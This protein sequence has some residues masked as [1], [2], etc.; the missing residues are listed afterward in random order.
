MEIKNFFPIRLPTG[1][2]VTLLLGLFF[3]QFLF[4]CA[5]SL[6]VSKRFGNQGFDTAVSSLARHLVEQGGLQGRP[7]LISPH[8]FYDLNS[9][10]SLPLAVLLRKR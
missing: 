8:D 2:L 3:G 9:K 1:T 6:P 7:V 10:L 5:S 4:G